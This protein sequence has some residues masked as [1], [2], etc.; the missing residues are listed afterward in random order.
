[1]KHPTIVIRKQ[2]MIGTYILQV[3]ENGVV[4]RE[5]K[6]FTDPKEASKRAEEIVR[7]ESDATQQR[8]GSE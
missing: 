1:M 7:E 5:E 8:T 2:K 4:V 6:G 3:Y